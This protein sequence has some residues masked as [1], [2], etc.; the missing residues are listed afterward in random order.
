LR[1]KRQQLLGREEED[2]SR[3]LMQVGRSGDTTP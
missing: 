3:W 1:G 2:D